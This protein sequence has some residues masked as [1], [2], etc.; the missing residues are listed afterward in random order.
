MRDAASRAL[1]FVRRANISSPEID[2]AIIT[3]VADGC[4]ITT[5][6]VLAMHE[7]FARQGMLNT[8]TAPTL[9][10]ADKRSIVASLYGGTNGVRWCARV[11]AQIRENSERKQ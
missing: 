8:M 6:D 4:D 7:W 1:V 9:S 11:V 2:D 3:G 10:G 5:R